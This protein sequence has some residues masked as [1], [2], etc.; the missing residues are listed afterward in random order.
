MLSLKIIAR[1]IKYVLILFC[2]SLPNLCS[3]RQNKNCDTRTFSRSNG[4]KGRTLFCILHVLVGV[5]IEIDRAVGHF[6]MFHYI[7]YF[8]QQTL[9]I[10]F[11]ILSLPK[12]LTLN[13]NSVVHSNFR[14]S[15]LRVAIRVKTC[16]L[17]ND[18]ISD[19]PILV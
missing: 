3:P 15:R 10:Q 5:Y 4:K 13:A 6:D 19:T 14:N 17:S 11:K 9:I 18:P 7:P 16:I 1:L 2:R 8:L 12:T